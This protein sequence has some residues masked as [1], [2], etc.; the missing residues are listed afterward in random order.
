MDIARTALGRLMASPAGRVARIAAGLILIVW[1]Y[2][3]LGSLVGIAL[4][5]IGLVPLLAGTFDFCVMSRALGGPLWG[6]DIR[7]RH[8][9]AGPTPRKNTSFG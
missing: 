9:Q 8:R 4:I 6:V 7:A 5:V 3:L 1:G 2:T